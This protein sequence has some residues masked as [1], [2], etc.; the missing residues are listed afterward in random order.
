MSFTNLQVPSP[1]AGLGPRIDSPARQINARRTTRRAAYRSRSPIAVA[2]SSRQAANP[3]TGWLQAEPRG[4][5]TFVP[6]VPSR[7]TFRLT[8]IPGWSQGLQIRPAEQIGYLALTR[9]LFS[10][11]PSRS[12]LGATLMITQSFLY[13]AIFFTYGLVLEFFFHVKATDTAYYFMAFA[14]GNLLGPLTIGW[15]FDTVGR[16]K[17][18]SGTYLV[19]GVLLIVSAQLF[20]AGALNATTQTLCWAVIFF[21]ASAGASAG[22]L[23]VSEVFRARTPVMRRRS[24]Q[25]A[26]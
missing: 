8:G 1:P 12:V 21:F 25:R 24:G 19:S 15:L 20:K 6:A 16:R 13:N 5:L 4:C 22:Y 23:T 9:V 10:H 17:M 26:R 11:Y 3:T 18:I 14:A 7:Q 2:P